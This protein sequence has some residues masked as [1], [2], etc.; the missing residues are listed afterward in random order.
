MLETLIVILLLLWLLGFGFSV[1]G[2]A[3]HV[4]AVIALVII[5]IRLL[6]GRSAL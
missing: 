1:G 6:Q 5:I 2:S 4:L 3:I